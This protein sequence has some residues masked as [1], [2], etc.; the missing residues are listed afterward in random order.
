METELTLQHGTKY[1]SGQ[2]Y[3]IDQTLRQTLNKGFLTARVPTHF[4]IRKNH[5]TRLRILLNVDD[6]GQYFIVNGLGAD[7]S[8]ITIYYNEQ[9]FL[10]TNIL[11]G[12]RYALDKGFTVP[13][14]GVGK[15]SLRTMFTSDW[16]SM[17][18]KVKKNPMTYLKPNTYIAELNGNPFIRKNMKHAKKE[19]L[20]SV[21][22]G[23]ME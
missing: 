16:R 23:I 5:I 22:Y 20:R 8:K 2:A 21:V 4:M 13:Q 3:E 12:E 19:T 7:I 18:K 15:K 17:E 10:G 6:N 9:I 11:A 1:R 14:K